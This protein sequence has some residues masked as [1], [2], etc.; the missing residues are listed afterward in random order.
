LETSGRWTDTN[1]FTVVELKLDSE[2][3]IYLVGYGWYVQQTYMQ[4]KIGA[5]EVF[6]D[7]MRG[8]YSNQKTAKKKKGKEK[9]KEGKRNVVKR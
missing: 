1:R 2:A 8:N 4:N 5:M 9:R 3:L 6:G 7:Q